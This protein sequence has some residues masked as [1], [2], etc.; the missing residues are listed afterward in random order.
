MLSLFCFLF[1]FFGAAWGLIDRDRGDECCLMLLF[2]VVDRKSI[3]IGKERDGSFYRQLS[4]CCR[5]TVE[6]CTLY[7]VHELVR[8]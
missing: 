6:P 7:G 5:C 1:F 2:V 4:L 3:M 8:S